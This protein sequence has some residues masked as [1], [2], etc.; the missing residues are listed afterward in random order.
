MVH[1]KKYIKNLLFEIKL[2]NAIITK[3]APELLLAI[4]PRIDYPV[5]VTGIDYDFNNEY[6]GI[7]F[8]EDTN[9]DCPRDAYTELSVFEL[10]MEDDEWT[11][12]I[13]EVTARVRKRL[14]KEIDAKETRE[15]NDKMAQYLALKS[16]LGM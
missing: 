1:D 3:R 4:I 2:L 8:V 15:R 6:V 14:K 5:R 11:E 10:A 16:E 9:S 7:H 12:H 13:V